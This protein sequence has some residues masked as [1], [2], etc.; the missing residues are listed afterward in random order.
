MNYAGQKA[1]AGGPPLP[2]RM[3]QYSPPIKPEGRG[4]GGPTA[5]PS[6][7][8]HARSA[9]IAGVPP[10]SFNI[11]PPYKPEG[12]GRGG[13]LLPARAGFAGTIQYPIPIKPE[14]RQ[15]LAPGVSPGNHAI[16]P[17]KPPQEGGRKRQ[18]GRATEA[19]PYRRFE[20]AGEDARDWRVPARLHG[21]SRTYTDG[22]PQVQSHG[23]NTPL[24][25][26]SI[27]DEISNQ[28]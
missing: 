11:P 24:A 20:D 15:T 27:G 5:F 9:G 2:A 19:R 26:A 18:D 16:H 8:C 12:R 7:C 28:R 22:R 25:A 21:Q 23:K 3:I 13:P 1:G 14:E 6:R 4:R 17:F 10:A